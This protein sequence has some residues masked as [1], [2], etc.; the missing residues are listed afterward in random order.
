MIYN[1]TKFHAILCKYPSTDMVC[2]RTVVYVRKYMIIFV[3]NFI[4]V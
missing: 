3:F 1:L 4:L 2:Q